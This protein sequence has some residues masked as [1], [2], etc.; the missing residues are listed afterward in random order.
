MLITPQ[1]AEFIGALIGD[2]YIY[3]NNRKYVI[4]FTGNP[5]TDLEYYKY[6]KY[7]IKNLWSKDVNI[8][9]RYRGI[10]IVFNSKEITQFLINEVGIS[11]GID[12]S[13]KITIPENIIND[14][15]LAKH[16][17]RGIVDTDGSIFTAKKPGFL[18]YPSIEITTS[19]YKLALQIRQTL[20]AH[21]FRVANIW[22]YKSKLSKRT[23]YKVPLNGIIN[24]QKWVTE[25]GFSNSYKMKKAE[26][27]L[28]G[29][30][31]FEPMTDPAQVNSYNLCHGL[32]PFKLEL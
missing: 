14:W 6:L 1:L 2:G 15:N 31:G 17:I 22:R 27:I 18:L 25:I 29:S 4:G 11:H 20:I 7:L 9:E 12:K 26:K 10:R 30:M 16:T 28:M 5:I 19:S 32:Q 13:E 21:N 8:I 3:T 23:T 24:I